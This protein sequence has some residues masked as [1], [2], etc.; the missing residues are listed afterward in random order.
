MTS[1]FANQLPLMRYTFWL[2]V[3]LWECFSS[4]YIKIIKGDWKQV[5]FI[6]K[7]KLHEEMDSLPRNKGGIYAF[8]AI[9]KV[10]N[11]NDGYLLYIGRAKC[12]DN[13]NLWARCRRYINQ[14]KSR[15]KISRMVDTFGEQLYIKYLEIEGN[16]IID[17]IE[18]ELINCLLPPCNEKIPNK[19]YQKKIKMFE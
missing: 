10:M 9:P 17:Q 1:D 12:T 18:N 15:P 2:H 19:D 6:N 13:Q 8:Y 5:K 14:E 16:D 3:N 4:K 7:G 11:N